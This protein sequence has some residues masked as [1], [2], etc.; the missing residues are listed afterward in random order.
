MTGSVHSAEPVW[1]NGRPTPAVELRPGD[2]VDS[3]AQGRLRR[4]RLGK[5]MVGQG[6]GTVW[7]HTSSGACI[8]CLPAER[9]AVRAGGITRYRRTRNIQIGDFLVRLV[10]GTETTDP[11]V[12]IRSQM[13]PVRA[14][15]LTMPSVSLIS[16]EGI[17]CR[18]S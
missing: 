2:E 18:P 1:A 8:R 10:A 16:E 7:L 12:A 11:V 9:L 4:A 17:V 3:F 13:E 6:E 15:Y 5:T 14:I